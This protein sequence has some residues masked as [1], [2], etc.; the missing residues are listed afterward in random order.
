[1]LNLFTIVWGEQMVQSFLEVTLPSLLQPGNIPASRD[2]LGYYSFYAS[3][4]AKDKIMASSLYK[5]L[6][7]SVSTRWF[8]L[9]SGEWETTSDTLHQLRLSASERCFVLI[10]PPDT[11]Y[12]NYS[13]LNMAKLC[14]GAHNPILF[15]FPRINDIGFEKVKEI[16]RRKGYFSNRELV[17]LSMGHLVDVTYPIEPNVVHWIVQGNSWK[18]RHNVPT[19]CI[20][21]DE[22]VIETFSTNPTKNSGYDHTL[23][24]LMVEEG[25]PWYLI[26]HSDEFFLVERGRHLI[27][28]GSGYD[29]N[30]WH[31]LEALKSL[32]FFGS[33]EVIWQGI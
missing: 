26:R 33:E 16:L 31:Q 15:G 5:Q 21:P 7:A 4:E 8:P 18:V 20:L 24:Y 27:I 3:D 25:Y 10:V 11:A 29:T 1:V 9:I 30:V 28:E 13:I 17:T 12:G 14:E 2:L 22:W 19:P 23:P 6:E 32:E